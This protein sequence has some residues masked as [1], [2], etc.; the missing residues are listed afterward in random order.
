M[1]KR[2]KELLELQ[3]ERKLTGEE[4][5][6]LREAFETLRYAGGD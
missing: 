1:E 3:K 2:I 6:E 4:I 5:E